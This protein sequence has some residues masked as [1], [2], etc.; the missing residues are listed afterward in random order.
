MKQPK[1]KPLVI[2]LTVNQHQKV[3]MRSTKTGEPMTKIISTLID[4]NLE[5]K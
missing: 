5:D 1:K 3:Y 4:N 2:Y